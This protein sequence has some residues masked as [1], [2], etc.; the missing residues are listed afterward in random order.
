MS[1]NEQPPELAQ[2]GTPP[3]PSRRVAAGPVDLFVVDHG[4]ARA[5]AD[6]NE[7]APTLLLIHGA[8]GNWS[9]WRAN[10]EA[11][12]GSYRVV[13]PD[14]PGF[15]M[16][17][18]CPNAGLEE[19]AQAVAGMADA[20]LLKRVV[21][22]GYSFGG[23]VATM[24]ASM[25]SD[26]VERLLIINPPGWRERSPDM[27][28]LQI[29]AAI[30]SKEAG[31]RA[32]LDFTLREIMLRHHDR[33]DGACLDASEFAVRNLRMISKDISRSVDLLALLGA[34]AAPWWVVF[35]SEDPYHR[36]RLD[37]RRLRLAQLKGERC[38]TLV[39]DAAHW[40]QQ[41]RPDA[42]NSFVKEFVESD[43]QRLALKDI[44]Q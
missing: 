22:I 14:L 19:L 20:L 30:R 18:D 31:L 21:L 24:L 6:A 35:S 29:K 1:A 25:R 26:L 40:L 23:L 10:I 32:G 33:I 17:G 16:S 11:L 39:R 34:V 37:E 38:T 15:G 13:V 5:S 12:S 27:K 3:W 8:Q 9:H 28:D 43:A 44:V 41:D 2:A 42:F 36:Y 4:P 7:K